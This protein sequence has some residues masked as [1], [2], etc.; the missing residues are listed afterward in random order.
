MVR[1]I[2]GRPDATPRLPVIRLRRLQTDVIDLYYLHRAGKG[3]PIEESVGA[4][5]DMVKKGHI[6]A[7]GLS[8]KCRLQPCAGRM[9]CTRSRQC[10]PSTRCGRAIPKLPYWQ[11]CIDLGV[12]FVAPSTRWH[13]DFWAESRLSLRRLTPMIFAAPCTL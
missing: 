12:T 8:R 13:A 4:L 3:V 6:R 7:I 11:T 9:Q 2:D 10:N 1:V 5:S